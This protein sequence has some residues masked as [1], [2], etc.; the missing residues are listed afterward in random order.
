MRRSRSQ[1]RIPGA[2]AVSA[3]PAG[4]PLPPDEGAAAGL[5]VVPDAG[6]RVVRGAAT[7]LLGYAVGFLLAGVSAVLLLRHLGVVDFGR[8][9]TVMALIGIVSGVTDAGLTAVG[10]RELALADEHEHR[11][12][13]AN[14]VTLRMLIT[15]I[16][17]LGAAL[18]GVLVGYDGTM[19]LGILV[20]GV[21][22]VL[23]NTQASAMMP[24]SV[25]LR[26]GIVTAVEILRQV[27]FL[28]G[29]AVLVV[30]GSGLLPIFALQVA[31]GVAVLAVSPFL[32]RYGVALYVGLDRS[33]AGRLVR[34]TMPLA[35]ALAMSVIYLRVLVVLTSL[36]S[37]KVEAGYFGTSF[38]VFEMAWSLPTLVLGVAL[39]VLSVAG[40]G[41]P[42]RLRN[43]LQLLSEAALALG[44][45][46]VVLVVPLAEP[47]VVVLAG[48][49]FRGAASVLQVQIVALALVFLGQSWQL[50]LLALHR[51]RALARAN[52]V[53]LVA[54]L[55]AGLALVPLDGAVGGA[56][57][58]VLGEAVLAVALYVMLRRAEP[59]V[60]PRLGFVPKVASA[61]G[62]AI[63][64]PFLLGLPAAAATIAGVGLYAVLLLL[65][66]AMPLE[67]VRAFVRR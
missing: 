49:S 67:V 4:V 5:L 47:A 48:E 33:V 14:L 54:V 21:G 17:V 51:E 23:I 46:V 12:L 53:A 3:A 25:D 27:V 59:A 30:A 24:L 1:A 66:R 11:R 42:A 60:A 18:F 56:I 58:A 62:A 32:A 7:R 16:G 57:A 50:G 20:A 41:D 26:L 15:P 13:M 22:V 29:V 64:V 8:F 55:V 35:L 19:L 10:T 65:L 34:E 52:A 43:A 61:A 40:R 9:A 2:D 37:T 36:L 63:L 38:R 45:L 39:P 44:A 31:I 6:G 28:I